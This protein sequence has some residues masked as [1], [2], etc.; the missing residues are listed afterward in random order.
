MGMGGIAPS[1]INMSNGAVVRNL[2]GATT[3]DTHIQ[4]IWG[5]KGSAEVN[6]GKS[7][8]LRLGGS[9]G[10]PK[11]EVTPSWDALGDQ[12]AQTGHGGGDFWVLYYFARQILTG[13]MAPFNIYAASDV[14]IPGILALRSAVEGGT[15]YDVPDFRDP[16]QRDRH[17]DDGWA[18]E[19][20]DVTAVFPADADYTI[21]GQF[22]TVMSQLI[23]HA[24]CYRAYADWA[25]VADNLTQ[26]ES[27]AEM[28]EKLI[29]RLPALLDTYAAAR[30][31]IDA[32]PASDGASVLRQMLELGDEARVTAPGFAATL[33]AEQA[34]L[35]ARYPHAPVA[36]TVEA[37]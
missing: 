8:Q 26:P 18:Q 37:K 19:P 11:M 22:S 13:E 10:S 31:I 5:T 15:P 30:R 33:H 20:Y 17:R 9:G 4:R 29:G 32:Y 6:V 23:D 7:L 21:T 27:V 3:N 12:A 28:L 24:L 36:V 1:L 34:A 35:L 16:A 25:T 2:M 14:T